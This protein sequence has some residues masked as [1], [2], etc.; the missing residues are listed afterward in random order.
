MRICL[1]RLSFFVSGRRWTVGQHPLFM[2]VSLTCSVINTGKDYEGYMLSINH[3]VEKGG[4]LRDSCL[5]PGSLGA[6]S[7]WV[8]LRQEIYV[9]VVTQREVRLRLVGSLVDPLRSFEATDDHTW[10][11]RAV[12]HCAE[13]LN[14][15]HGPH[16]PDRWHQLHRWNEDWANSLPE[17][18][19]PIFQED[20]A[21]YAFPAI[22][23]RQS[24]HGTFFKIGLGAKWLIIFPAVIGVQHHLLAR[25]FIL[26][27]D[28][29]GQCGYGAKIA[30]RVS[31]PSIY[32]VR[33]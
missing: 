23:Y 2:A 6:A 16:S 13:V 11:N 7:F 9:A 28:K 32:L 18:Y 21:K 1:R 15:V 8:G 31:F 20:G 12:L 5:I 24:C 22:W 14:F 17:S 26:S 4:Q 10:A 19:A 30:R 27:S 29:A 33:S 3:F 25:L